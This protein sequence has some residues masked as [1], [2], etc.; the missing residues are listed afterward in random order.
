MRIGILAA[1]TLIT[2]GVTQA[3][4]AINADGTHSV[5]MG[6]IVVNP[7]GTHSVVMG[8]IAIAP[9]GT[10]SIIVGKT[11]SNSVNN[12]MR[13]RAPVRNPLHSSNGSETS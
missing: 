12:R 9:D 8:N 5:V 4:I 11:P 10:H 13:N 6:N 7:N 2:A 3:Q 1:V